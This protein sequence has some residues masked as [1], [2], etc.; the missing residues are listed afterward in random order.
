MLQLPPKDHEARCL[1]DIEALATMTSA[2]A[3]SKFPSLR[4]AIDIARRHFETDPVA[5]KVTIM[6]WMADDR[7]Q[8]ISFGLRGGR[9]VIWNFGT[10]Y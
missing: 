4:Q 1:F 6:T 7:L 2:E 10:I 9:K 5:K 3:R 8:L